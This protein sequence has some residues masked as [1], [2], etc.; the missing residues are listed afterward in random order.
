MTVGLKFAAL[1]GVSIIG[2]SINSSA[3]QAEPFSEQDE[4][5]PKEEI[6][7]PRQSTLEELK[8]YLITPKM[9]NFIG[10]LPKTT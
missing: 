10:R 8:R 3:Q 6:Y 4:T 7:V 5:I 2:L 1:F 9:R